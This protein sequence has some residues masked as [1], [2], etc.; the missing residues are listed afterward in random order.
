MDQVAKIHEL[1]LS[2][3]AE[4]SAKTYKN[5]LRYF[6]RWLCIS[7]KVRLPRPVQALRYLF[8]LER[9]EAFVLLSEYQKDMYRR[10]T[11]KTVNLRMAVLHKAV[12]N[13]GQAGFISWGDLKIS[14]VKQKKGDKKDMSGPSEEAF[15]VFI[16]KMRENTRQPVQKRNLA[17][18]LLMYYLGLRT[19]EIRLARTEDFNPETWE[20]S[21]AEKGSEFPV[22][23]TIPESCRDDLRAW[24]DF[25]G[26]GPGPLFPVIEN[27]YRL[28]RRTM[29]EGS[30]TEPFK[31]IAD[32]AGLD[33][34]INPHAIRHS[35]INRGARV[36]AE[37]GLGIDYLM[38][39]SRHKN[40]AA[41]GAYLDGLE[42]KGQH[43]ANLAAGKT[44]IANPDSNMTAMEEISDLVTALQK[45]LSAIEENQTRL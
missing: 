3:M 29:K 35:A 45:K 27:K 7:E 17:I 41:L 23:M 28:T 43:L 34:R 36:A 2:R 31:R 40:P 9:K 22:K 15:D 44:K 11:R 1:T 24:I 4:S 16:E 32:H 37:H 30:L 33:C 8:S 42:K 13:A 12:W 39:F 14:P 18:A 38:G 26:S 20:L 19:K 6:A 10:L 25:R 21:I 5:S